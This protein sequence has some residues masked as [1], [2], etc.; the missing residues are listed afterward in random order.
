MTMSKTVNLDKLSKYFKNYEQ[1]KAEIQKMAL[2]ILARPDPPKI[3]I[4][5]YNGY[6]KHQFGKAN[7]M[8]HALYRWITRDGRGPEKEEVLEVMHEI[9]SEWNREDI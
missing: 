2:T 4:K 5:L 3:S 8:F 6:S 9:I 1:D 7:Q